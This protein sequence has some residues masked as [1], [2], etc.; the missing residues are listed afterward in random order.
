MAKVPQ[1]FARGIADGTL[2]QECK[3]K[4]RANSLA[5]AQRWSVAISSTTMVWLRNAADPQEPTS[6]PIGRPSNQ[7]HIF[8]RQASAGTC[9]QMGPGF[10]QQQNGAQAA[11]RHAFHRRGEAVEGFLKGCAFGNQFED[12]ALLFK[13]ARGSL[14]RAALPPFHI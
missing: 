9:L 12:V 11:G 8:G 5:P 10:V 14:Q 13:N 6:G 1:R 2:Q 4:P 7:F 3:P